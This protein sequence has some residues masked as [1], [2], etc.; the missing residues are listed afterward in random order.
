MVKFPRADGSLDRR[1]RQ[2]LR[3]Q[4]LLYQ[5]LFAIRESELCR[6]VVQIDQEEC[7]Q[8]FL[9]WH[10]KD[11]VLGA[12]IQAKNLSR[13]KLRLSR[14]GASFPAR[15]DASPYQE[16]RSQEYPTGRALREDLRRNFCA[17]ANFKYQRG[18]RNR[19]SGVRSCRRREQGLYLKIQDQHLPR[20]FFAKL[21]DSLAPELLQLLTPE[22]R[23]VL[24][25]EAQVSEKLQ[26]FRME[27]SLNPGEPLSKGLPG[28]WTFGKP[29]LRE[30]RPL[31]ATGYGFAAKERLGDTP[32]LNFVA[33]SQSYCQKLAVC[34]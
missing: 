22:F 26:E 20:K 28:V 19:N 12:I 5:Q 30:L 13:A 27:R 14:D 2:E 16:F 6:S 23:N 7:W 33:S 3:R 34:S 29:R 31:L 8:G 21:P 15:M 32:A 24:G 25:G 4:Y 11:S 1:D 17:A 9:H 10:E 18:C